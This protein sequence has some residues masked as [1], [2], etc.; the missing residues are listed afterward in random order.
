MKFFKRAKHLQC[1]I[2]GKNMEEKEMKVYGDGVYTVKTYYCSDDC[3]FKRGRVVG[4]KLGFGCLFYNSDRMCVPPDEGIAEAVPCSLKKG[5]YRSSCIVYPLHE[6]KVKQ[7]ELVESIGYRIITINKHCKLYPNHL[8]W[9]VADLRKDI[10][11]LININTPDSDRFPKMFRPHEFTVLH[12]AA[13]Y[14]GIVEIIP[15]LLARGADVNILTKAGKSPLHLALDWSKKYD[16]FWER[17]RTVVKLLLDHGAEVNTNLSYNETPLH[18]AVKE[19]D[20]EMV[21]LLLDHGAEV[22]THGGAELYTPL[23]YAAGRGDTEIVR[24]LLEGGAEVDAQAEYGIW[25]LETPLHIAARHG[26]IEVVKLLLDWGVDVNAKTQKDKTALQIAKSNGHET[27]VELL[28]AREI[29]N[30]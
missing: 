23:H 15:L 11:K 1:A 27:I 28:Q 2:C 4:S 18:P 17:R 25:R 26:H 3:W 14:C 7:G 8:N 20:A 10:E 24:V 5:S 6:A 12:Y 22:N 9:M 21:K 13:M 30:E 19:W 16:D 29:E